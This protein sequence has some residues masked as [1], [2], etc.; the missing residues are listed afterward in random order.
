MVGQRDLLVDQVAGTSASWI[1]L[2]NGRSM[3]NSKAAGAP[4]GT[5]CR[6]LA[7]KPTGSTRSL[8]RR[9]RSGACSKGLGMTIRMDGWQSTE[10]HCQ[11]DGPGLG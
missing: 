8:V 11:F 4:G 9:N 6:W 5:V 3:N 2:P 10:E 7:R 1:E